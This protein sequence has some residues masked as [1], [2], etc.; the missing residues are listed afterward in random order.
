MI[1]A[2]YELSVFTEFSLDCF[3]GIDQLSK[4]NADP[5]MTGWIDHNQFS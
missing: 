1:K 4:Q 2:L 5:G 3:L